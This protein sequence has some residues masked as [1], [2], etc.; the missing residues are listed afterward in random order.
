M[1]VQRVVI[2]LPSFAEEDVENALLTFARSFE[3]SDILLLSSDE[4]AIG[5]KALAALKRLPRFR[6]PDISGGDEAA[7]DLLR[8]GDLLVLTGHEGRNSAAGLRRALTARALQLGLP[9]CANLPMDS[10]LAAALA[11]FLPAADALAPAV[12]TGAPRPKTGA[13]VRQDEVVAALYKAG[14]D[15]ALRLQ[16]DER[17]PWRAPMR[18]LRYMSVSALTLLTPWL[19]EKARLRLQERAG[20]LR[21]TRHALAWE[22]MV[23]TLHGMSYEPAPFIPLSRKLPYKTLKTLSK[24]TASISPRRSERFARSARKRN[25]AAA[26]GHNSLGSLFSYLQEFPDVPANRHRRILVSDY[27]LPRADLSAGERAT[28]GVV[29]DLCDFGFE[30]TFLP[31]DLQ[32]VAPYRA[33]LEALGAKVIT[34]ADG[35]DLA[36]DYIAEHGYRY[37]A[38]Y[39]VRI[40][41][42]EALLDTIR[43]ISPEAPVIFHAPDLYFL[44]EERAAQLSGDPQEAKSAAETRRRET[45]VMKAVDH[46]LL[47]SPAEVPHVEQIID[48]KKITVFPALYSEVVEN[49]AGFPGRRHFFFLGGFGHPPNVHG[50]KWFVANVWP[51]VHRALPDAEFHI[52]GA[53]ATAE[54]LALGGT[55]G[56]KVIGYV[57]DLDPLL[58]SYRVSTASL[59][60]GAGIKGKVSMAMGAGIPNVLT[61]IAAEGMG[62]IDGVHALVRDDPAEFAAA[63]VRL[64]QDEALWVSV[65]K[66]GAELVD[67]SFGDRANRISALHLLDRTGVLPQSLYAG[68]AEE[69]A[70]RAFRPEEAPDLSVVLAAHHR[71]SVTKRAL[72]ALQIALKGRQAEVI[73]TG[74]S[75]DEAAFQAESPVAGLHWQTGG[76]DPF[77][78]ALARAKAGSLLL[79]A[80]ETILMPGAVARLFEKEGGPGVTVFDDHGI[81]VMSDV[82]ALADR[83][84]VGDRRL[85]VD[86]ALLQ[87]GLRS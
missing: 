64:Y 24:I 10:G 68:F 44:R 70:P 43:R 47:V 78:L 81:A 48:R 74:S 18:W 69:L 85:F 67:D 22:A 45:A 66:A 52:I 35:Y 51:L 40:D 16:K 14:R 86:Q 75:A 57:A 55:P 19:S 12:R 29:R 62:I 60:F 76:A 41:V 9:V 50:V 36:A 28:L 42:V 84:A 71:P 17:Q 87:K 54:V 65:A 13:A 38:Y 37:G 31:A 2:V 82:S 77:G 73:V 72:A 26:M 79:L 21:P 58:Q 63:C 11:G 1:A 34:R 3:V 49:P 61:G 33:E 25:P 7:A 15:M 30:V 32:D 23:N 59:L 80:P 83:L 46:V 56:V 39:L 53:E 4:K 8:Q 20:K 27:R 5:N 6:F